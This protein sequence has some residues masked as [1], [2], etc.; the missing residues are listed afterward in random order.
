LH[1]D[2]LRRLITAREIRF[3]DVVLSPNRVGC[4]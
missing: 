2:A 4:D 3:D 1:G